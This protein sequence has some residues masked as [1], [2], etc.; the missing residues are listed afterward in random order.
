MQ[1]STRWTDLRT[2]DRNTRTSGT[3]PPS[4]STAVLPRQLDMLRALIRTAAAQYRLC[5]DDFTEL[6]LAIDEASTILVRHTPL[7]GV[8]IRP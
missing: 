8:D 4:L 3:P 5:V 2:S 6:L 1:Q 7:A